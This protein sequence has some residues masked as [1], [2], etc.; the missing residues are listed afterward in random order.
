MILPIDALVM[1]TL[2]CDILV[3][4]PFCKDIKVHLK[5]GE[6]SI[7]GIRIP[8]GAKISDDHTIYAAESFLLRNDSA[9]VIFPGEFL[10]LHSSI[11]DHI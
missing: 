10:E 2:D 11:L 3:G 1:E 8:Y 7:R 9:K 5:K 6:I 4:I